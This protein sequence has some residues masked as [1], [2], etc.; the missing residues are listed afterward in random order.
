MV[1]H[2]DIKQQEL[3]IYCYQTRIH[4]TFIM[5][6]EDD[7]VR[8]VFYRLPK[9]NILEFTSVAESTEEGENYRPCPV[10]PLGSTLDSY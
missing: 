9:T 1:L 3:H 2:L 6:G 10:S 4:N 7:Y 5:G 8:I